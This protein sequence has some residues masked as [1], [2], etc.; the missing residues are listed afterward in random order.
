M[1]PGL[2]V[3]TSLGLAAPLQPQGVIA[4]LPVVAFRA[5]VIFGLLNSLKIW[6]QAKRKGEPSRPRDRS[7]NRRGYRRYKRGIT[8]RWT[9]A[10]PLE[11]EH[12]AP[13]VR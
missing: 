12:C 5:F 4:G 11:S 8:R 7:F 2:D 6:W 3:T 13:L 10:R 9:I 1:L